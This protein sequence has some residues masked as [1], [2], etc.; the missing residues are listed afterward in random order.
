MRLAMEIS[1]ALQCTTASKHCLGS[2]A[3]KV[4][5]RSLKQISGLFQSCGLRRKGSSCA[6]LRWTSCHSS[7]G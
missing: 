6:G 2:A 3:S 1:A 4:A 7:P 5:A